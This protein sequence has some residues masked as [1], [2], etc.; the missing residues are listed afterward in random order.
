MET[1]SETWWVARRS[2]IPP[3]VSAGMASCVARLCLCQPHVWTGSLSGTTPQPPPPPTEPILKPNHRARCE[4]GRLVRSAAV[5]WEYTVWTIEYLA[6]LGHLRRASWDHHRTII[7]RPLEEQNGGSLWPRHLPAVGLCSA[8]GVGRY[9]GWC[10]HVCSPTAPP[11]TGW[12][13]S[14]RAQHGPCAP[15]WTMTTASLST[16]LRSP[17]SLQPTRPC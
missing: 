9:A 7:F 12:S 11:P 3:T 6:A 2:S 4:M 16:A 15:C 13:E 8:Q 1:H 17:I 14:T 10:L 5:A